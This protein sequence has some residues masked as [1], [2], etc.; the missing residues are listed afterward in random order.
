MFELS[1]AIKYLTPRWRQLSVSIISL[2]SILVIALVVWL[3]VVFFSV[4][5]GLTNSWIDKMIALTAPVRVTPTEAYYNSHY[6]NVDGVSANSNYQTKTLREKLAYEGQHP[7]DP[8]TDEALPSEWATP[9]VDKD[10][11]PVDLVK[12]VFAAVRHIAPKYHYPTA[13]IFEI[14]TGQL[15]LYIEKAGRSVIEQTVYL[16]SY[17]SQNSLLIQSILPIRHEDFANI[18]RSAYRSHDDSLITHYL[19]KTE[20]FA[21][22]ATLVSAQLPNSLL[23]LPHS[24]FDTPTKFNA[25]GLY[26]DSMLT[27]ILI[28]T[29]EASND[30]IKRHSMGYEAKSGLLTISKEGASFPEGT[31]VDRRTPAYLLHDKNFSV[32]STN[33]EFEVA[34]NVQGVP[35]ERRVPL[36]AISPVKYEPTTDNPLWFEYALPV[37]SSYGNA[38]LL[39][40]SYRDAGVMVGDLGTIGYSIPTASAIQE[41]RV[42]IYIAGFY[43][44]GIIP[45]GGKFVIADEDLVSEVRSAQGQDE[46]HIPPTTG[47]NIRLPHRDDA[48]AFKSDLLQSLQEKGISK[49]WKV[50]TFQ[51]FDFARD[52]LKQLGS[53]KRLFSLL[54]GIIIIVACSNI[55][56]MLIILV[57][58]KK[59]EI[60]ILRSMGASSFSIMLIFGTCG[61][62]MGVAGSLLGTLA[63][64]ITLQHLQGLVDVISW[65]QGYE[66]FNP[67][68]YGDKLPSKISVE[69]FTFVVT[70]TGLISLFAGVI[71]AVKACLLKP[72]ATLRSE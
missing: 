24:L 51:E 7:Y 61:V 56:S 71:P 54:A 62:V 59:K 6:H 38:V 60:G 20:D 55:I 49:Y 19:E 26:K 13:S 44:P 48:D 39:P 27:K 18:H 32:N 64:A 10:G 15:K 63:A 8:S 34:L 70:A 17:D 66:M 42:P 45:A 40:K 5:N 25:I 11:N 14:G 53:E 12:E 23:Y 41:Q 35:V 57:N 22:A 3:V 50:E 30:V 43:D 21:K 29:S 16:G 2:I 69:A 37:A 31:A 33:G 28:P 52:L 67:V 1:V 65:F 9:E 36:T 68:F 47:I 4:T 46:V 58:D 72:S